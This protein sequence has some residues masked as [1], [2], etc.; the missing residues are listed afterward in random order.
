MILPHALSGII[1]NA[2][3][4]ETACVSAMKSRTW[5]QL[6]L[7]SAVP[8]LSSARHLE[9]RLQRAPVSA[10]VSAQRPVRQARSLSGMTRRKFE[11][12]NSSPSFHPFP[13]KLIRKN[14]ID[15][16]FIKKIRRNCMQLRSEHQTALQ[17]KTIS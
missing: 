5:V 4:A 10:A 6:I 9:S 3:C 14:P 2:F 7:L 13:K 12:Q 1:Q 8:M 17:T 11:T 15:K 16:F